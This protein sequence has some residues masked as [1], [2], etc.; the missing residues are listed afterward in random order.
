MKTIA[1][2]LRT[3]AQAATARPPIHPA[4]MFMLAKA[5]TSKKFDAP[6]PNPIRRCSDS[7]ARSRGG[8][9][10]TPRARASGITA[11]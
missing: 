5:A 1:A 9:L 10:K 2:T 6:A 8:L 4:M 11:M 3:M 7:A